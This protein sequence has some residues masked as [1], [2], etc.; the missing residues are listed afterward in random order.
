[1]KL[2]CTTNPGL[3]DVTGNELRAVAEQLGI[4]PVRIIEAPRGLRGHVLCLPEREAPGE[5][6]SGSYL[7]QDAAPRGRRLSQPDP[8][9]GTGRPWYHELRSVSY[10]I[11]HLAEFNLRPDDDAEQFATALHSIE[12]PALE[13]ASSFRVSSV[14]SGTHRFAS[15]EIERAA[16][17]VLQQRYGVPVN[18]SNC[19]VDVRLDVIGSHCL[20]GVQLNHVRLDRRFDRVYRPR[21]SLR[22]SVAFALLQL[23]RVDVAVGRDTAAGG[24]SAGRAFTILDPFCGSGTILLESASCYP[25]ARVIGVDWESEAVDG[26]RRNAVHNGLSDRISILHGDAR[27]LHSLLSPGS[28]DIIVTN[29]PYGIRLAKTTD[30]RS[31]YGRFLEAAYEV[32]KP[33]GKLVVLVGRRRH[34]FNQVARETGLWHLRHVR[35]IEI[36]GVY[37]GVFVLQKRR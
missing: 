37:P 18:L 36:S 10:A 26:A 25:D 12:V 5:T 33:A 3:E 31:L 28:V 16:G 30:F 21:V 20:V 14:R 1:M 29:P 34:S 11:D 22:A 17:A 23:G 32:L 27:A 6:P 15:P 9:G 24:N 13:G 7:N 35:V 4:A 8:E 19:E 2:H